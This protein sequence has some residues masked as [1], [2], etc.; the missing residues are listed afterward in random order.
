VERNWVIKMKRNEWVKE[1][2][3]GCQFA[4]VVSGGAMCKEGKLINYCSFHKCPR[5]E[6]EKKED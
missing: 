3:T 5:I 6:L 2:A 4:Q 1:I